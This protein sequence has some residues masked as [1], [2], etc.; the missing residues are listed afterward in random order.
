MRPVA[1]GSERNGRAGVRGRGEFT[2]GPKH[3]RTSTGRCTCE[4]CRRSGQ[5]AWLSE[6]SCGRLQQEAAP[7]PHL[8]CSNP[9]PSA[10]VPES[11]MRRRRMG[12]GCVCGWR[13]LAAA[14][15][16]VR[17]GRD[18]MFLSMLMMVDSNGM[19]CSL[20]THSY[21]QSYTHSH[22]HTISSAHTQLHTR[23]VTHTLSHV[24]LPAQLLARTVAN[25]QL[26]KRTVTPRCAACARAC[27]GVRAR[28]QL[29]AAGDTPL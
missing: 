13:G 21:A 15:A 14:A 27:V 24:Q 7:L 16:V 3:R 22:T 8:R 20:R 18:V 19:L 26:H 29:L 17:T 28:A 12:G 2:C 11:S 1:N 25:P 5:A 10:S 9:A 4:T 23:T 6:R